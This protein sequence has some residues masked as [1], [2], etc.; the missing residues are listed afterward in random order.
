VSAKSPRRE[1]LALPAF[2]R[3]LLELR[4]RGFVPG[5][6]VV[7]SLDSWRYGKLYQRL[8]VPDDLDPQVVDFRMI[9]G[10]DVFVAWSSAR[11]RV[12]RRDS[13]IR[14][15]V[16]CLPRFL[17]CCDIAAPQESF[18]VVSRARGLELPEYS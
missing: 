15:L 10:L 3:E 2:G 18:I 13:L 14:A 6:T 17:W 7:V 4:R 12:D 8:V 16:R 1:R 11:T 9:A 5:R